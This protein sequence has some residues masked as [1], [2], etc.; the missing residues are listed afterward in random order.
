MTHC[1][2]QWQD[3]S[4]DNNRECIVC[5]AKGTNEHTSTC[6]NPCYKEYYKEV[7]T[8]RSYWN[9]NDANNAKHLDEENNGNGFEIPTSNPDSLMYQQRYTGPIVEDETDD[10]IFEE[11]KEIKLNLN[12]EA[13][14]KLTD[15]QKEVWDCIMTRGISQYSAA[16]E[17]GISRNTLKNHIRRALK[18]Y[19]RYVKES[20]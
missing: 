18:A 5:G 4:Y 6:K 9:W 12:L 3:G 19:K 20:K 16:A 8:Q 14:G 7:V 17:L 13:Y 15:K 2:V 11:A 10:L 1:V